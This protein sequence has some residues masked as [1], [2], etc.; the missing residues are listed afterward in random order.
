MPVEVLKPHEQVIQK[1]VDQL[2]RMTIRWDAYTKPL[3][4]DGATGTILDGHHRFEI[5]RRLDLQ[6]LP[7]VVV[8]YLD[9]DSITLLL[10]PNSD[11][12]GITKDDVIQAGL[13]GDLMPPKTSRHLLSDDLPPISVP[14][15]RLMDPAIGS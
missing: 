1:K 4:V 14:L 10:W 6:C 15:S 12:E 2:E 3:L 13:S 7:C 5:A 8:D 11:R 9:D